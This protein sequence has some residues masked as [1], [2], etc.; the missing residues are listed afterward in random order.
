MALTPR[1]CLERTCIFIIFSHP[2]QEHEMNIYSLNDYLSSFMLLSKFYSF[3]H[4]GPPHFLLVI[5]KSHFL[6]LAQN[7]NC[8]SFTFLTIF[9]TAQNDCI[10][11][12]YLAAF[13]NSFIDPCWFLWRSRLFIKWCQK[14]VCGGQE[15]GRTGDSC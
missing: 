8:F 10:L 11:I 7:G 2:N 12:S 13:L 3:L 6:F 4:L 15:V 1:H 5:F 9:G 14:T